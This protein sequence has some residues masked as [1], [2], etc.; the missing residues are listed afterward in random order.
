LKLTQDILDQQKLMFCWE[1][2]TGLRE[3][4]SK[5]VKYDLAND[6]YGGLEE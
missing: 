1:A 5:M 3:L 2:N 6:T 4:C